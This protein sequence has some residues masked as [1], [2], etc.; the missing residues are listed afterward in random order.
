M[1]ADQPASG[2][3]DHGQAGQN[4]PIVSR[5]PLD[6]PAEAS[7]QAARTE[8]RRPSGRGQK[9]GNLARLGSHL[10]GDSSGELGQ[11]CPFV[12]VAG[13]YQPVENLLRHLGQRPAGRTRPPDS[14]SDG[15]ALSVGQVWA[16]DVDCT[17][18]RVPDGRASERPPAPPHR[19]VPYAG[20]RA[21][22][23][24]TDRPI[25]GDDVAVMVP[26]SDQGSVVRGRRSVVVPPF[27][28]NAGGSSERG[29]PDVVEQY[30]LGVNEGPVGAGVGRGERISGAGALRS[31]GAAI[32]RRAARN[33][34]GDPQGLEGQA[35]LG[36]R[37]HDTIDRACH[38]PFVQRVQILSVLAWTAARELDLAPSAAR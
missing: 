15:E 27:D 13:G 2:R 17:T 11:V 8:R 26:E 28:R 12:T 32:R 33:S 18:Y 4:A 7:E 38:D 6:A 30:V 23:P 5:V 20:R 10:A 16:D 36:P 19:G 34:S 3:F 9:A 29:V 31:G 35:N 37:L 24:G 21:H 14:H 22:R 25:G 1:A